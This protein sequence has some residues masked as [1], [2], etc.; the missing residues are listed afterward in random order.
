VQNRGSAN[1]T[2][3]RPA[4]NLSHLKQT[5]NEKIKNKVKIKEEK[6]RERKKGLKN[7]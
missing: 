2:F 3:Y 1:N 6:K 7:T 4:T 5:H